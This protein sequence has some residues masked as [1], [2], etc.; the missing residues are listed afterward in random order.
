MRTQLD[1]HTLQNLHLLAVSLHLEFAD[2]VGGLYHFERLDIY[3]L[4]GGRS[5]VDNT[6]DRTFQAGL[7]GNH[8]SAV[9]HSRRCVAVNQSVGDCAVKHTPERLR[10]CARSRAQ[11]TP[12]LVETVGGS[13]FHLAELIY[14]RID[15]AYQ[16]W[17]TLKPRGHFSKIGESHAFGIIPPIGRTVEESSHLRG[18]R[19]HLHQ[20]I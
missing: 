20:P 9:A 7:D 4:A 10:H 2:A 15:D 12:Q 3:G 1:R 5:I 19:H 6:G 16:L 14:R 8:H 17:E 11:L 18:L 13:V